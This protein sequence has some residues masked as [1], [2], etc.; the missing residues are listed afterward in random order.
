VLA[1]LPLAQLGYHLARLAG[2]HSYNFPSED[3]KREHYATIHRAT[4]GEPA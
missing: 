4:R 2:K 1:A 3:A